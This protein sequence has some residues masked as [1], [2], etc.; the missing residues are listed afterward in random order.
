MVANTVVSSSRSGV[1]FSSSSRIGI[2]MDTSGS[3]ALRG[4]RGLRALAPLPEPPRERRRDNDQRQGKGH[5]TTAC[6]HQFEGGIAVV[7]R[8]HAKPEIAHAARQSDRSDE[9]S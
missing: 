8:E 6:A 3:A 4:M 1:T 9:L 5:V 7:D 2:T